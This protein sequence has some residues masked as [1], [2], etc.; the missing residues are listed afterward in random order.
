[1]TI[2]IKYENEYFK[3]TTEYDYEI[4]HLI[5][6]QKDKERD[7]EIQVITI[8]GKQIKDLYKLLKE[9]YE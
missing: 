9:I 6:T 7:I 5:L 3:E 8:F 4:N 2:K 1:M